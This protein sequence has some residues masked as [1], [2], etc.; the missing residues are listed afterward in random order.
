MWIRK[1][2]RDL[3]KGV[4]SPM[5]TQVVSNEEIIP[6]P[7]SEPQKMVEQ[8]IGEMSEVRAKK[9]GMQ[10]RDFMR[11]SMGMATCFLASN[12]VFGK[13]WEVDEI[14]TWEAAP[15]QEKWPKDEYFIVDVQ[16]HFTNG[17]PIQGFRTMEFVKNMGFNLKDDAEAYGFR[18]FVKEMFFDS[19]T[20]VVV[21]SGVP[22]KENLR[23][24]DGKVL[25]GAARTPGVAGRVLPSWVM[26]EARKKIN[27]LAGSQRAL[28][29]GNLAPNH[30]WDKATNKMNK[31]ELLEQ[32]EREIKVYG[33][34]SWKWYCHTDPAQTGN[35]FQL[36]DENAQFFIEESR[37]RGVKLISTHKGYSYQSRTLGHLANPKDVEKAALR[38]PD[39]NFVVYHSALKHG[40]NEPNWKESN[41]YDPNTGDFEWH[42]VLMDIKKRNPKMN[43]V[44]CEIGSFFNT[45]AVWD[46][47]MAQHGIGKNIKYYGSDHV[48]WGTDC[49]WWGSPQWGID[50]FKRF[51]ISDE[52]C[53]KFGY[54]KITN[55]DKAKIFGLNA[56][57]LYNIDVKAKRNALPADALD[58]AKVA[59]LDQ[60]GQPSN[61]AYGWVRADD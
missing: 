31:A 42:S 56:A 2:L 41:K 14:E 18:N 16:A 40:A 28:N 33:I 55:E 48:V 5:P 29:Q 8:L 11:T 25:E 3:K 6:R 47:V 44:Y 32:M 30:Y 61:A 34:S 49:L 7:Q 36:D 39:F 43:N 27:E 60:G 51:Q 26:Y 17:F 24:K 23:D 57:K 37:K 13:C 15:T 9:L 22:G 50:A 38:N 54:K 53:E 20:K 35:G 52:L 10:R 21:I 46:P 19:D 12:Q 45:L 1:A 59:Y 58:K 4:D